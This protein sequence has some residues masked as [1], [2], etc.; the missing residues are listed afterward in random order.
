MQLIMQG[1]ESAMNRTQVLTGI[2]VLAM[3][4]GCGATPGHAQF[5]HA[6]GKTGT[7]QQAT[8]QSGGQAGACHGHMGMMMQ[9]P[10][11]QGAMTQNRLMQSPFTQNGMQSGFAQYSMMQQS[12]FGQ[13]DQ[14]QSPFGQYSMMTAQQLTPA[15][16]AAL[17]QMLMTEINSLQNQF[18]QIAQGGSLSGS[19]ASNK[20]RTAR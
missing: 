10:F 4:L 1:E 15:Q 3:F 17:M 18:P 9:S 6:A 2:A 13:G 14:A 19:S 20:N 11:G 12:S 5:R 8:G 16:A 7:V